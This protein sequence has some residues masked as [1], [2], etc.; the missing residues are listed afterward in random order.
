M[1]LMDQIPSNE[2]I[3]WY[4][5]KARR[6]SVLEAVFNSMLPFA[7]IWFLFDSFLFGG[8][9]SSDNGVPLSILLFL[10][11][12]MTPVWL[13]LG[14]IVAASLRAKNTEYI[15]TDKAVYVQYGIL[16]TEVKVR[17]YSEMNSVVLRQSA[18]DKMYGTGDVVMSCSERVGMPGSNTRVN[19][20]YVTNPFELSIENI[21]EYA[22]VLQMVQELQAEAEKPEEAETVSRV[23]TAEVNGVPFP[24]A[25]QTW[26]QYSQTAFGQPVGQQPVFSDPQRGFNAPSGSFVPGG[27]PY[28]QRYVEQPMPYPQ[29]YGE[30]PMPYPQGYGEQQVPYPQGYGEQQ[31]PYPQGYGEQPVPYPQG[32]GEQPVPYPQGYG[33][34]PVPYSQPKVQQSASDQEKP[35]MP[36]LVM[37]DSMRQ[38][39]QT[40]DESGTGQEGTG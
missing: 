13:Y 23:Q 18:F 22:T 7:L 5:R 21:D 10:L 11:L 33:E 35:D 37:P 32:Y 14:G 26:Q 3:L 6:V 25:Q 38:N 12:H 20:R 27:A 16:S 28:P 34:Q 39:L 40:P 36:D 31:V 17:K 1:K 8:A 4:G 9:L 30:Q 15:V 24:Q 19:G 29:G 2:R